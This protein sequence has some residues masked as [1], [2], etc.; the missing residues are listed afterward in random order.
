MSNLLPAINRELTAYI[1]NFLFD[2]AK[3]QDK[4]KM[5]IENLAVVFGP[6]LLR[7]EEDIGMEVITESH[8][9]VEILVELIK[10]RKILFI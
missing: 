4:N 10:Q 5:T 6:L 1:L 3:Y 2:V 7:T 8:L 9:V